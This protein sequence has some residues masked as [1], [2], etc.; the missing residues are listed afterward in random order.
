MDM[1]QPASL[2]VWHLEFGTVVYCLHLHSSRSKSKNRPI[3]VARMSA[4]LS[5]LCA[6]SGC[7]LSNCQTRYDS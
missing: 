3:T 4:V 7:Y 5:L 2:E 1:G 6:S